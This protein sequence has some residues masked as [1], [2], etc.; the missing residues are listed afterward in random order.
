MCANL[1][2]CSSDARIVCTS[3]LSVRM[4]L[5]ASMWRTLRICRNAWTRFGN[6]PGSPSPVLPQSDSRQ[7]CKPVPSFS[8][9]RK[10]RDCRFRF[11]AEQ[12]QQRSGTER[13][14]SP[15]YGAVQRVWDA[16]PTSRNCG[17]RHRRKSQFRVFMGT[18]TLLATMVIPPKKGEMTVR[19]SGSHLSYNGREPD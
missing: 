13:A 14:A 11:H 2:P 17:F 18:K 4:K 1:F 6:Y 19:C 15:G 7:E 16:V 12:G 8:F 9:S 10:H 5:G 3:T